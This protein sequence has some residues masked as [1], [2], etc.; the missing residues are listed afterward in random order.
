MDI[1]FNASG[2]IVCD[3]HKL[4]PLSLTSSRNSFVPLISLCPIQTVPSISR[5]KSF[6][7][8]SMFHLP[9]YRNCC[10]RIVGN[11]GFQPCLDKM[12]HILFPVYSPDTT[13][14]P[15][16]FQRFRKSDI[17][18]WYNAGCSPCTPVPAAYFSTSSMSPRTDT[19]SQPPDSAGELPEYCSG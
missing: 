19:R 3:E 13:F 6:L 8:F 14:R 17:Y 7:F 15:L 4:A 11:H 12:L 9:A 10:I 18:R 1:I 16:S 5:R 2:R